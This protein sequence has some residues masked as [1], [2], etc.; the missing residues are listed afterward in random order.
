MIDVL[1]C[2][3]LVTAGSIRDQSVN[4]HDA[5][6]PNAQC[7]VHRDEEAIMKKPMATREGGHGL[8]MSR[9]VDLG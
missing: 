1:R 2:A 6:C 8:G 7:L 9:C 3:R 4:F 5:L